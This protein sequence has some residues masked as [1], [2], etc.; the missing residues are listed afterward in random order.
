MKTFMH[1]GLHNAIMRNFY[2]Y[3]NRYRGCSM[4]CAGWSRYTLL[5]IIISLFYLQGCAG[6]NT[7][8]TIARAGD[9]VSIMV[10]GSEKARK[11]TSNVTL[12]DANSVVWDLQALGLVRSVFN[13]RADGKSYGMHYSSYLNIFA[14]WSKDHES[15]QTVLVVDLPDSLPV[16]D[17][18]ISFNLNTDDD[19]SGIDGANTIN[20]EVISGAG[21]S[22][23][24]LWGEFNVGIVS[25]DLEKLEPAP[26]AKISFGTGGDLIGAASLIVDFD[27]TVVNPDDINVYVPESTVRGSYT[28]TGA[29]GKTQRMV[30]WHHDGQKMFIDIVAPQE[31]EIRYLKLYLVHPKGLSGLV[32]FSLSSATTYDVNGSEVIVPV[33]LEYFP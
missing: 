23:E 10:G 4:G 28:E 11:A 33:S 15:M 12:T 14:P 29:F 9:T 16:G 21:S 20:L 19:S 25:A 32:N 18:T 1:P 24:F 30:Y 5:F 2:S 26:H 6:V 3:S 27:E 17:A 8:P 31:I 22:D 7:F 13:L